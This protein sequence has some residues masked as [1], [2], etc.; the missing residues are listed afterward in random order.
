[1]KAALSFGGLILA[2][3]CSVDYVAEVKASPQIVARPAFVVDEDARDA[4]A[5]VQQSS[6]AGD[7][8]PV[9]E[10]LSGTP[11]PH[12]SEKAWSAEKTEEASYLVIYREP[13]G[14]PAYAFE[15][16]LESGLVQPTPEAVDAL[17]IMRVREVEGQRELMARAN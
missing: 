5:L 1:M 4:I 3:L 14:L 12:G 7:E 17:A 15:V 6:L 9:L 11:R 8:V 16:D 13:A 10:R 2:F